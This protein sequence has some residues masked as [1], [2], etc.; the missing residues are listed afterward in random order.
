M[1]NGIDNHAFDNENQQ[2]DGE[3]DPKV[4]VNLPTEGFYLFADAPLFTHPFF[5]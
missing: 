2:A 1:L 3:N 4:G 5:L